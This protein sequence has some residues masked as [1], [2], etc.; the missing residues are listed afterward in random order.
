MPWA[1]SCSGPASQRA[2]SSIASNRADTYSTSRSRSALASSAS[3][4][5][6]CTRLPTPC[7][8]PAGAAPPCRSS[9]QR[10]L[11][12][13]AL[14]I[15]DGVTLTGSPS[16]TSGRS[17]ESGRSPHHSSGMGAGHAGGGEPGELGGRGAPPAGRRSGATTAVRSSATSAARV[18]ARG[19]R[20]TGHLVALG[21][22]TR[23]RPL[24]VTSSR[25]APAPAAGA[26]AV[27]WSAVRTCVRRGLRRRPLAVRHRH[28]VGPAVCGRPESAAGLPGSSRAGA[29][30]GASGAG[31]AVGL[32][33]GPRGP[34]LGRVGPGSRGRRGR[35]RR[36][37]VGAAGLGPGR[38]SSAR[39]RLGCSSPSEPPTLAEATAVTIS[40]R[41]ARVAAT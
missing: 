28:G 18:S 38:A 31:L 5:A 12:R 14:S 2:A 33:A 25:R 41:R 15:E 30:V 19:G 9:S 39:K 11:H 22:V 16:S 36:R 35:G 27:G 8:G 37:V 13:S 26:V 23:R 17:S 10:R 21:V 32:A 34:G 6:A 20:P 40:R 24:G 4:A 29:C 7:A 3:I 1:R